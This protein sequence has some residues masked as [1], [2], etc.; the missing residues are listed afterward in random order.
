MFG[1]LDKSQVHGTTLQSPEKLNVCGKEDAMTREQTEKTLDFH[2]DLDALE[3]LD[4]NFDII[5]EDNNNKQQSQHTFRH[6][7]VLIRL[8]PIVHN[9]TNQVYHWS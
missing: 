1:V 3:T 6:M 2:V 5:N 4:I 7:F 8:S 9:V